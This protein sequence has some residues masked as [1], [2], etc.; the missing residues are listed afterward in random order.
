MPI[1]GAHWLLVAGLPTVAI[2]SAGEA[3]AQATGQV[4][5]TSGAS[6]SSRL[7]SLQQLLL[8]PPEPRLNIFVAPEFQREKFDGYSAD[9]LIFDPTG[10][11]PDEVIPGGVV[12][13]D[14]DVTSYS[15]SVG[16]DY[17]FQ[18]GLLVG[19]SF[20]YTRADFDFDNPSA[21]QVQQTLLDIDPADPAAQRAFLLGSPLDRKFNEYG[22]TLAVGYLLDPWTFLVAGS[23]SRRNIDTRRREFNSEIQ[24]FEN[25]ASFNSNNYSIDGGVAYRIEA[26]GATIQP[27][28][29]I[30]YRRE[31]VDGFRE[32]AGRQFE[33]DPAS[34][35][36]TGEFV[37]IGPGD[38]EFDPA[39]DTRR[40]F[41]SQTI[42]SIPLTVGILLGYP[43]GPDPATNAA[44]FAPSGLRV[45]LSYTH[46]FEDQK[47]TVRAI[48]E[49]F[50]PFSVEF[51]EENRNRNFVTFTGSLE[52]G[53]I[54]YRGVF[55]YEHDEGFDERSRADRVRLQLRVP[56]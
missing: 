47:R 40:R 2:F 11:S 8:S 33:D 38:P 45:G 4:Q 26:G 44:I 28:L 35:F 10:V 50:P 5:V 19:A 41:N 23:Y 14:F 54:G 30:G 17:L 49:N 42:E 34:P 29:S 46:D 32:N 24:F 55:T 53:V 9:A 51:E 39:Q 3:L 43:L 16:A 6:G 21:A 20:D 18:N 13:P 1:R 52:F 56:L 7:D 22:G 31:E 37:P 27:Q 36:I 48:S 12:V 25:E 15:V